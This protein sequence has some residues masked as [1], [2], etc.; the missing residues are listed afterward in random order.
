MKPYQFRAV[1]ATWRVPSGVKSVLADSA[2]GESTGNGPFY[3][4]LS[5]CPNRKR[6]RSPCA[7]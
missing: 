7:A 5:R 4:V 1:R 3:W 6:E 2:H